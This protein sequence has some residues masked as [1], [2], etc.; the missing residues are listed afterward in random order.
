M[1]HR[2]SNGLLAWEATIGYIRSQYRLDSTLTL[3]A[4]PDG[5]FVNWHA[6]AV[7][8]QNSEQVSDKP[9]LADA[10]RDLWRQIDRKHVIFESR[11]ALIRRPTNYADHEW[12][13]DDT[14]TI[15]NQ[16]LDLLQVACAPAWI[17]TLIYEP[18][19]I[20]ELRF[21]V[22]LTAN[23]AVHLL[24]QGAT[25]QDACRDLYRRLAQDFIQRSTREMPKVVPP[26]LETIV[27]DSL[28]SQQPIANS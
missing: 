10:L 18:V 1:P 28:D 6:V 3:R 23:N 19:E 13:D 7:W 12:L 4:E 2:P 15:L 22:G 11:E 25:L 21:E 26:E 24:G 8:G 5:G 14:R 9:T 17:L 16:T 27:N 20:P